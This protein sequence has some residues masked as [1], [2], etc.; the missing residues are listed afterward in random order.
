MPKKK[1]RTSIRESR[2]G[3][4]TESPLQRAR[5]EFLEVQSN[6]VG[7]LNLP[8]EQRNKAMQI[9]A[10]NLRLADAMIGVGRYVDGKYSEIETAKAVKIAEEIVSGFDLQIQNSAGQPIKNQQNLRT[11]LEA[12]TEILGGLKQ[13]TNPTILFPED[14]IR[15]G[16]ELNEY[17]LLQLLG[18]EKY[19]RLI[20]AGARVK[21]WLQSHSRRA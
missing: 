1:L 20:K 12:A 18:K 4:T 7:R 16:M 6:L 21:R 13:N 3:R 9:L 8:Q 15:L 5:H 17:K 14:L 2:K 19:E 11:E 10:H